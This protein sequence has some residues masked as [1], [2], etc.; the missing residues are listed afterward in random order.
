MK[1]AWLGHQPDRS[2]T[3]TR[4][5][6]WFVGPEVDPERAEARRR[7]LLRRTGEDLVSP[8]DLEILETGGFDHRF[9]LCFQ[10][11]ASDSTLP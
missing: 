4:W 2:T 3:P 1:T 6:G 10:Q 11:S 8:S 9:E 5:S 7:G